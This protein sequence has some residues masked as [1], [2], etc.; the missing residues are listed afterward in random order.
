MGLARKIH[1]T[2]AGRNHPF[3]QDK[4]PV[5]DGFISHYDEV[6]RL[7]P[8]AL[9]LASNDFTRVQAAAVTHRNGTFWAVQYHPEYDLHEMARLLVAREERLLREGFFKEGAEL[10]SLV[11]RMEALHSAPERKDLRWQLAIDDDVLDADRRQIEFANWL[12]ALVV[13]T[14]AR[15]RS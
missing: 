8:G 15:R 1:L 4:P 6:T 14:A 2:E 7:P 9:H 11:E 5:F 3:Y 12:R 13:P 10:V